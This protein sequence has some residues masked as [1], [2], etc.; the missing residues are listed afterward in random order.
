ML[1][2]KTFEPGTFS[3]LKRLME[4]ASLKP[5]SLVVG[6]AVALH[7]GHRSSEDLYLFYHEKFDQSLIVQDLQIAFGKRFVYKQEHTTFGIFA[8]SMK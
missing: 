7:Y 1:R 5:F 6:T 3:I 4:I 2:T 8:L